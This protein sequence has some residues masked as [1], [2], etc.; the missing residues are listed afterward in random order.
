MRADLF[1]LIKKEIADQDRQRDEPKYILSARISTLNSVMDHHVEEALT[2]SAQPAIEALLEPRMEALAEAALANIDTL[3]GDIA[4]VTDAL[5][6]KVSVLEDT[7]LAVSTMAQ[8][9]NTMAK[10]AIAKVTQ[11]V[12]EHMSDPWSD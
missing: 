3:R 6:D 4:N 7:V 2:Q 5:G 12:E 1:D 8:E 9:N 11:D 10:E